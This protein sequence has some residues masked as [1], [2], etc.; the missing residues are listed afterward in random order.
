VILALGCAAPPAP[1]VAKRAR[2]D[3]FGPNRMTAT[4]HKSRLTLKN[5]EAALEV[6]LREAILSGGLAAAIVKD[7]PEVCADLAS[8]M[9][10]VFEQLEP[11][12]FIALR[13][14]RRVPEG[15]IP[16]SITE[17]ELLAWQAYDAIVEAARAKVM[18]KTASW[19]EGQLML[20]PNVGKEL[21]RIT[22][23]GEDVVPG[24]ELL[25]HVP[26][27]VRQRA[28]ELLGAEFETAAATCVDRGFDGVRGRWVAVFKGKI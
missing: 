1:K 12:V 19:V 27:I 8:L 20:S 9:S 26:H 3:Y 2:G 16:V 18:S 25:P 24:T 6:P 21:A 23:V 14:A 13:E 10:Y 28:S 11:E 22:A 17:R 7:T 4:T 5:F 15:D